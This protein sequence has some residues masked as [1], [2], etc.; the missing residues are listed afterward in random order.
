MSLIDVDALDIEFYATLE[1]DND[2]YIYVNVPFYSKEQ[3]DSAN[4]QNETN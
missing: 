4:H 1:D 2:D 3:I